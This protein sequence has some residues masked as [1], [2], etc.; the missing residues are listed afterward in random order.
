MVRKNSLV[1]EENT[2]SMVILG[3]P[4]KANELVDHHQNT[5]KE[6]PIKSGANKINNLNKYLGPIAGVL[7]GV[8]TSGGNEIL[9]QIQYIAKALTI[10]F[11]SS[12]CFHLQILKLLKVLLLDSK[13]DRHCAS[14]A[15]FASAL[16]KSK[17]LQI[18]LY[19]CTDSSFDVK[20]MCVKLID[21][22]AL[23]T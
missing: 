16:L 9:D 14:P 23:H 19:L 13:E 11:R 4:S 18:L 21:V 5:F 6:Q 1:E 17:G 8:L 2:K 3:R 7:E 15:E 22:L 20:S 10:K 12:N